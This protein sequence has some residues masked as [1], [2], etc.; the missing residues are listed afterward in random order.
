[1][2]TFLIVTN[3]LALVVWLL[4]CKQQLHTV[5]RGD[6]IF[7]FLVFLVPTALIVLNIGYVHATGVSG[8]SKL[9]RFFRAFKKAWGE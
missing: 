6:E 9:T 2:R 5:G 1:M 7:A 4:I 3:T 8:D